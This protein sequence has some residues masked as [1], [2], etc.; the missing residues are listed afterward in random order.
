MIIFSLMKE[1]ADER[2]PLPD[3]ARSASTEREAEDLSVR[4]RHQHLPKLAE[5]GYIRWESDPF[6]VRRGPHFREP[7]MVVS[8]MSESETR[9]PRRLRDDCT[10]IG[11]VTEN[12]SN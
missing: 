12:V 1:P 5:A 8:K 10:I 6:S 7:A 2:L 3:A 4:L 11:E 9:L